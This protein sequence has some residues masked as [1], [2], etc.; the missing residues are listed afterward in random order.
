MT[1]IEIPIQ[2]ISKESLYDYVQSCKG[3]VTNHLILITGIEQVNVC[4]AVQKLVSLFIESGFIDSLPSAMSDYNY[5]IITNTPELYSFAE[6]DKYDKITVSTSNSLHEK[7]V[8]DLSSRVTSALRAHNPFLIVVDIVETIE[9]LFTQLIE[10][11][12]LTGHICVLGFV[13]NAAE[14]SMHSFIESRDQS[15]RETIINIHISA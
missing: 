1:G 6:I 9:P 4:N 10:R 11:S 2:D 5:T 12:V 14:T 3:E 8:E 13:G 15:T 7:Q